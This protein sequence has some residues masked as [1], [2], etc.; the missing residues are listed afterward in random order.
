MEE[1]SV[2]AGFQ[3]DCAFGAGSH[4]K[5]SGEERKEEPGSGGGPL[6]ALPHTVPELI[7]LAPG[8]SRWAG[9]WACF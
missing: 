1:N 8:L 4:L 2:G 5:E 9:S 6:L 7:P 3:S